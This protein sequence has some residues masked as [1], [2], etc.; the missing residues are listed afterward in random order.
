[1]AGIRE[2]PKRWGTFRALPWLDLGVLV[3]CATLSSTPLDLPR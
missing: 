3:P 1:M 2:D